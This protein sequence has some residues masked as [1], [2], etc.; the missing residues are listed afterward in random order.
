VKE[1]GSDGDGWRDPNF[2]CLVDLALVACCDVLDVLRER[3][4]PKVVEESA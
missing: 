4:P 3:G 2:G 1:K